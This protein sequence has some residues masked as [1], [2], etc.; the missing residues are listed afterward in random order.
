MKQINIKID[1]DLAELIYAK[2]KKEKCQVKTLVEGFF[3]NWL[4]ET[5][6][7][8]ISLLDRL[9]KLENIIYATN[10]EL[11]EIKT[12]ENEVDLYDI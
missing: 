6:Q 7:V 3:K 1:D 5:E 12:I 9:S 2:I 11:P 10:K 8:E 4:N